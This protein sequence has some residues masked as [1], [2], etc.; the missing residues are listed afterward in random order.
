[1]PDEIKEANEWAGNYKFEVS[2]NLEN[3]VKVKLIVFE[4]LVSI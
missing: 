3:D 2:F 4:F 1:M